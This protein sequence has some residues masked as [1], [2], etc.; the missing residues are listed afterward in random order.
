MG[1]FNSMETGDNNHRDKGHIKGISCDVRNCV[2]HDSDCYCTA[3]KIA[4]G[5]S[6]AT[7]CT[8]TVCATFKQ[9]NI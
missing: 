2:Y 1:L 8:D 9:R 5:P 7:S 6:Y 3:E 4:V